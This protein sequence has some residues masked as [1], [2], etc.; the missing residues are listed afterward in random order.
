MTKMRIDALPSY[1]VHD[2]K[3]VQVG[4]IYILSCGESVLVVGD[5][6]RTQFTLEEL[7]QIC[8]RMTRIKNQGH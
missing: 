3:G 8:E 2:S 1:R 7:Q 5:G 6:V 4:N